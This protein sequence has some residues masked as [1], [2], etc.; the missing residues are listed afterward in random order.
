MKRE[1]RGRLIKDVILAVVAWLIFGLLLSSIGELG[2]VGFI[3]SIFLAGVPFGW[4]WMSKIFVALSF[5]TIMIKLILSMVLGWLAIFVVL[6][7]DVID[8]LSAEY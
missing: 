5:T 2:G 7:K 6:I 3:V 1:A 8:Y 4:R